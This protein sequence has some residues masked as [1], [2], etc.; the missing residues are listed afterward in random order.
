MKQSDLPYAD[1]LIKKLLGLPY[2]AKILHEDE[3]NA[4][5]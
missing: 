4:S 2:D 1:A 5:E 3:S